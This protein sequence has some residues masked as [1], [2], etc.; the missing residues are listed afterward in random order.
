MSLSWTATKVTASHSVSP[1]EYEPGLSA[2]EQPGFHQLYLYLNDVRVTTA[3]AVAENFEIGLIVPVKM[4][5]SDAAFLT[6]DGA[7][8]P[9]FRS[10]HHRDETVLGLGD[11]RLVGRHRVTAPD[12]EYIF[13]LRA[14]LSVPTGGIEP[15]PYDLGRAGQ[16]H[17]HI[18]FG[19][20]TFNPFVG[21]SALVPVGPVVLD[22]DI[23]T[24]GALYRN[25]YEYR[26]ATLVNVGFGASMSFGDLSGDLSLTYLKE[27][28][29]DWAG[30]RA[31]NSGRTDII[32][33]LG[34]RWQASDDW[35]VAFIGKRPI[36][37]D[38]VGGQVE[39]PFLATVALSYVGRAWG[40][41]SE[42]AAGP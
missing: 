16:D 19:S 8:I 3:L 21:L 15:N 41:P 29:A 2:D 33:G 17:Q 12:S 32:P 4:V 28:P 24:T 5:V 13:D 26:S 23:W 34:L 42:G 31:E 1:E 18:F 30:E 10:I 35:M 27:F 36:T 7:E 37:I 38:S 40:S 11:V 14:G 22:T 25:E 9:D 6:A 39:F 20:G